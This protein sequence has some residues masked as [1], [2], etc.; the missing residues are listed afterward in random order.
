MEILYIF[1]FLLISGVIA[2]HEDI[3]ASIKKRLKDYD[4]HIVISVI[5]KGWMIKNDIQQEYRPHKMTIQLK[6]RLKSSLFTN[7][8]FK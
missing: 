1:L 5:S 7:S 6:I 2:I 4:Y 8:Y 3:D